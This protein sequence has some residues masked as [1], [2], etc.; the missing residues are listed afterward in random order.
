MYTTQRMQFG[1]GGRM[2]EGVKRLLI[3]NIA[4]F[5]LQML[6]GRIFIELFGLIP[7]WTWSR[8]FIWQFLT[9]MFL[10]GGL[11]HLGFNMYALWVF[12]TE[13]ERM[14]GTK[15]FYRYYLITGIGAGLIHTLITPLSL[16]PTIGASGAVMGVLLAFGML[17]PNRQITLLL[18]FILPVTLR[19]RNLVLIFAGISILSGVAGSPDGIAHFAHLGGML[20]GYLYIKGGLHRV[21][22]SMASGWAALKRKLSMR[23]HKDKPEDLEKL[24]RVVDTILDK[25]NSVGYEN[26]TR[27][28]KAVLKK[29]SK[30]FS[31]NQN[32][33]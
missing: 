7:A 11:L 22:G 5:V 25:A 8:L 28:E 19:A 17:F 32:N 14:W 23:V 12:G 20:V 3:I 24:Q 30:I 1:F 18:F 33:G 27:D 15:A 29:A 31:R 21:A 6:G 13:V 9:Y 26:L 4:V 2:T 16:I 10:H